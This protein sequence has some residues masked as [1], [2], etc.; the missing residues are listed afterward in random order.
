MLTITQPVG[1]RNVM[2]I[3]SQHNLADVITYGQAEML[4]TK[5]RYDHSLSGSKDA[6]SIRGKS[7][8][9]TNRKGTTGSTMTRAV[10]SLKTTPLHLNLD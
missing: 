6:K 5:S 4:D 1:Q 3:S 8:L 10:I 9:T 2:E 7:E